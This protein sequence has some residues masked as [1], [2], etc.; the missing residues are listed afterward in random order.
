MK[1]PESLTQEERDRLL[2]VGVEQIRELLSL[3]LDQRLGS[4]EARVLHELQEIRETRNQT[5]TP[6]VTGMMTECELAETLHVDARTVRRL[7]RSGQIPAAIRIGCSKRF[8][9][10]EIQQWLAGLG[11][12]AGKTTYT[13]HN[14]R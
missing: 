6:P 3:L 7:E 11:D 13:P 14:E 1:D 8:V 4:L 9:V 2:V 12:Q 10:N 5:S